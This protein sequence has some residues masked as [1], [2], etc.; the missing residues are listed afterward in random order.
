MKALFYIPRGPLLGWGTSNTRTMSA[1]IVHD[2]AKTQRTLHGLGRIEKDVLHFS[3]TSSKMHRNF[4]CGKF[5]YS[6]AKKN[7]IFRYMQNVYIN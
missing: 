2:E 6:N 5:S 4:S 1:K 7:F 3:N